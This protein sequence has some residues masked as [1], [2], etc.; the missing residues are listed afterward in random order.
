MKLLRL[1]CAKLL[2]NHPMPHFLKDAMSVTIENPAVY[3]GKDLEAMSFALNYHQWI[4]DEFSPYIGPC[5]AEVGAGTG[6]FS[7]FVLQ[8]GAKKLFAFEPS[9]NMYP[10]LRERF[11]SDNR[12]EVRNSLFVDSN[13]EFVESFDS[14]LYVNVLEHIEL[15]SEELRVA[16]RT[17]KAGGYL[18]IF[19]PA[20]QCL[21]SALDNKLGHFRRYHK[22]DLCDVVTG[23]GF[24]ITC[25]KYFDI[26]GIIPW[27]L[28]FVLMK[29]TMTGGNVSAYDR[30]VVPP[31]RFIEG[32]L[33]PPIGKNILLV[34]SKR[35]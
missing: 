3:F 30:F 23:A 7:E 34:A 26:A 16:Y 9:S 35:K 5:A 32:L 2:S 1:Y 33:A 24:D 6:N 10:L 19:V 11:I 28:A 8:R 31:M 12:V 27:Y 22:R 20:L 14:V 4:A 15:D 17:I 18:L 21:Y 29:K 25:V 13:S